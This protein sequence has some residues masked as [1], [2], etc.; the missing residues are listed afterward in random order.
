MD[1]ELDRE[2]LQDEPEGES[3][4][5]SFS[6]YRRGEF[7]GD[8]ILISHLSFPHKENDKWLI[9]FL[10]PAKQVRACADSDV[11][12][13]F[14]ALMGRA[15]QLSLINLSL[16]ILE[17]VTRD[18]TDAMCRRDLRLALRVLLPF[19]ENRAPLEQFW[20]D[21]T[22]PHRRAW[23]SCFDALDRVKAELRRSGWHPDDGDYPPE[24]AD[25]CAQLGLPAAARRV[26]ERYLVVDLD[27]VDRT[28][29]PAIASPGGQCWAVTLSNAGV[30]LLAPAW[31][32]PLG[33]PLPPRRHARRVTVISDPASRFW[34]KG[35]VV[36]GAH[37]GQRCIIPVSEIGYRD[38]GSTTG[39][40][41][42]WF[43]VGDAEMFSVAGQVFHHPYHAV[44]MHVSEAN[45]LLA[46][47]GKCMPLIL[48]REDEQAWLES[49]DL[50]RLASPFPSQLMR[51]LH[52]S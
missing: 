11:L 40:A 51:K 10:R 39:P 30:R 31:G 5:L 36:A 16:E 29:I 49:G 17:A 43:T 45:P 15:Y 52:S 25:L 46:P 24:A 48:Q 18:P 42:N 38:P 26:V 7:P 8:K 33:P 19:M 47:F 27:F 28:S 20:R 22:L 37:P 1:R 44:A 41:S 14:R 21:A 32:L 34:A 35:S 6:D 23:E 9:F 2:P 4:H 13:T 12:T 3:Y 50:E